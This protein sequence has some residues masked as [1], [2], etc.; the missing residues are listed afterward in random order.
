MAAVSE[1]IVR[2]YFE[3]LGYLVSE[4]CKY[5]VGGRAKRAEEEIDLLVWHPQVTAPCLPAQPLWT[6]ADLAGIACAVVR[7]HGWHT[8][9]FYPAML[10]Q[11]PEILRFADDAVLRPVTRRMGACPVARILCL[12]QLPASETLRDEVLRALKQKGVDGVLLFRT[13][14]LALAE[15]VDE[16]RNYEKSDL[17][18]V[19]R[20]L[21]VYDLL[22]APQMDLFPT[23]RRKAH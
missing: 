19:L 9:R 17:L 14:L 3:G 23:R 15:R 6:T 20:L 12:S 5:A 13:L 22:K 1:W 21:K 10:E 18:Q 7:I 4:P 11:I 16:N 2:E 8:E